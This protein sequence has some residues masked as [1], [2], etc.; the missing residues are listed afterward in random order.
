MQNENVE[1]LIDKYQPRI[2]NDF[3]MDPETIQLIH[4]LMKMNKFNLLF[5][6]ESSCGKTSML[7]VILKE[8]YLDVSEK[9]KENNILIISSLK[10]Q[11]IHYYR[12]ELKIF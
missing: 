11:G 10:E 6:G 4:I 3:L 7:N 5:I 9:N 8:Y 2:L 12:N 1:L